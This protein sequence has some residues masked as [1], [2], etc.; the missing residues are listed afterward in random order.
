MMGLEEYNESPMIA[1]PRQPCAPQQNQLLAALPDAEWNR[2]QADLQL[3]DLRQDQA[4][5]GFTQVRTLLTT[6]WDA[7]PVPERGAKQP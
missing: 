1:P 4:N 3:V 7:S 6:T 2:W 5:G